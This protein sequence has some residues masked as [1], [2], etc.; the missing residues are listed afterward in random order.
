MRMKP[1]AKAARMMPETTKTS[2]VPMPLPTISITG[3]T[4]ITTTSGALYAMMLKKSS[5]VPRLP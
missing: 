1:S 4:P 5:S 3:I 2:G